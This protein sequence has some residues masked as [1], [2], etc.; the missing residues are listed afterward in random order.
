MPSD[1]KPEENKLFENEIEIKTGTA[2]ALSDL[3]LR[4]S[5]ADQEKQDI[6]LSID[7]NRR[8]SLEEV[9]NAE[10]PRQKIGGGFSVNTPLIALLLI[11]AIVLFFYFAPMISQLSMPFTLAGNL[12]TAFLFFLPGM[13][14][15]ARGSSYSGRIMS[16]NLGLGITVLGWIYAMYSALKNEKS[17]NPQFWPL[18]FCMYFS[19]FIGL[20]ICFYPVNDSSLIGMSFPLSWFLAMILASHSYG[21]RTNFLKVDSANKRPQSAVEA[22]L[23]FLVFVPIISSVMSIMAFSAIPISFLFNLGRGLAEKHLIDGLGLS[24]VSGL[25]AMFLWILMVLF[26]FAT[27]Y[28]HYRLSGIYESSG[29]AARWNIIYRLAPGLGFFVLAFCVP[30]MLA[31]YRFLA[32]LQ[33]LAITFYCF[34]SRKRQK[35]AL[36]RQVLLQSEAKKEGELP[37]RNSPSS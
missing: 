30:W 3:E 36:E 13:L 25:G 14:A 29:K 1:P 18:T 16:I 2:D 27:G 21:L 15:L 34:L 19:L 11:M 31:S 33:C 32:V 5:Y 6:L 17:P 4:A 9:S 10:N 35:A 22:S 24:L 28:F 12:A 8:S 37:E 20:G 26:S 7:P 23:V